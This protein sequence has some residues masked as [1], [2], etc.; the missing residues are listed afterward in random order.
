MSLNTGEQPAR[1]R[2]RRLASNDR[3]SL[4]LDITHSDP[5]PP[6]W[7]I[8]APSSASLMPTLDP[9]FRAR[10][11]WAADE[12]LPPPQPTP[13]RNARASSSTAAG[14]STGGRKSS[15]SRTN[16]KHEVGYESSDV[17]LVTVKSIIL[18]NQCHNCRRSLTFTMMRCRST[19][20]GNVCPAYFCRRCIQSDYRGS[21]KWDP[22][23][24]S[25]QCP[26]CLGFCKCQ[27]C[28]TERTSTGD[29]LLNGRSYEATRAK[30]TTKHSRRVDDLDSHK[31]GDNDDDDDVIEIAKD[32]EFNSSP[33]KKADSSRQ[34]S[35]PRRRNFGW[36]RTGSRNDTIVIP[37]DDEND[38]EWF[39]RDVPRKPVSAPR[40]RKA[41]PHSAP[42][43][44]PLSERA[45]SR[46]TSPAK[47]ERTPTTFWRS[48]SEVDPATV[49]AATKASQQD[50]LR[51][52]TSLKIRI[53]RP[54]TGA[55]S[56]AASALMRKSVSPLGS[57]SSTLL[58]SSSSTAVTGGAAASPSVSSSTLIDAERNVWVK[59]L[60]DYS[61]DEE[62]YED[63]PYGR[64]ATTTG[65]PSGGK[66][67]SVREAIERGAPSHS[68]LSSS[69]RPDFI[70]R[71]REEDGQEE[72]LSDSERRWRQFS[73]SIDEEERK[74]LPSHWK[75]VLEAHAHAHNGSTKVDAF[76][77][78]VAERSSHKMEEPS[79]DDEMA[80]GGLGL[81]AWYV[82]RREEALQ[83][84]IG[85]S[86][87]IG[88][89]MGGVVAS[90]ADVMGLEMA[91]PPA[92]TEAEQLQI[93][94]VKVEEA[95]SA[96]AAAAAA[97]AANATEGSAE[98]F[99]DGIG[100]GS[101]ETGDLTAVAGHLIPDVGMAD[102]AASQ[103][104][105]V[106]ESV[107]S[108][109]GGMAVIEGNAS[110]SAV[111]AGMGSADD[112]IDLDAS[113]STS[114]V[115]RPSEGQRTPPL[116]DPNHP[117]VLPELRKLSVDVGSGNGGSSNGAI[118][119]GA[120]NPNLSVSL[121]AAPV[122]DDVEISLF[123]VMSTVEKNGGPLSLGA[124]SSNSVDSTGKNAEGGDD[125]D[126]ELPSRGS[127]RPSLEAEE[128]ADHHDDE[129]DDD[130][131][132]H[133]ADSNGGGGIR[134]GRHAHHADPI[135][136]EFESFANFDAF[137]MPS[138]SV[139]RSR[140]GMVGGM[141]M[142]AAGV[143]LPAHALSVPDLQGYFSDVSVGS[144]KRGGRASSVEEERGEALAGG[145]RRGSEHGGMES[146]SA[147]VVD[148]EVD[149]ERQ[150]HPTESRAAAAE[151]VQPDLNAVDSGSSLKTGMLS[152]SP[153]P[154][155]AGD[156]YQEDEFQGESTPSAEAGNPPSNT[157]V[158]AEP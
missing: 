158:H 10:F 5:R 53:K 34:G 112:P 2:A 60:A 127:R 9:S 52:K 125:V 145:R 8:L 88:I 1:K 93:A 102:F 31:D 66:H 79:D 38:V 77:H 7:K 140:L 4:A 117:S 151:A 57:E 85:M 62:D 121:S 104:G 44:P 133:D 81:G 35:T 33:A 123:K 3:L 115:K 99:I 55:F 25:F 130:V 129:E 141:G 17:E 20:D 128:A 18:R 51:R 47:S 97:A 71:D 76:G 75:R 157:A 100:V 43:N 23:S 13:A 153:T 28:S 56:A 132:D 106:Y 118:K 156:E 114:V 39:L 146:S 138:V 16:V 42:S 64:S 67:F 27:D 134:G 110:A 87:G 101:G 48:G 59:G 84:G 122:D 152:L 83:I 107:T 94:A 40:K 29:H 37:D 131:D 116:F 54:S 155:E 14:R 32:W 147:P 103:T 30:V 96:A 36:S 148:M 135:L 144:Q 21:I 19:V 150:E 49:A 63:V 58:E 86:L 91:A 154:S 95:D 119:A 41:R 98:G 139:H 50:A 149:M 72:E 78:G 124:G 136:R 92:V 74:V 73:M 89:G 90:A 109:E 82:D 143:P 68:R 80:E 113:T 65:A 22:E 11:I 105:P 70:K 69:P 24:R 111:P 26:K 142:G 61:T 6:G 15:Q 45:Q 108:I 12:P 46:T 137:V 126:H 120:L